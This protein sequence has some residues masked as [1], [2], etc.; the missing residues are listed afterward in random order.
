MKR[1]NNN[2]KTPD[3]QD[4]RGSGIELVTKFGSGASRSRLGTCSEDANDKRDLGE[5][6]EYV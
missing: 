4:T 3:V 2:K 1:R 6:L 5:E